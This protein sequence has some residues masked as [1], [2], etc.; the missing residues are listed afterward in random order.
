MRDRFQKDLVPSMLAII[1]MAVTI[2][3][4]RPDVVAFAQEI[5]DPDSSFKP[6]DESRLFG[7]KVPD[8][9]LRYAD[10]SR[11]RL[12]ELW[13]ERPV[14]VTLVFSRCA[15]ICSPYLGLLKKTVEQVGSGGERYQMLVISFDVRDRPTDMMA[16]A[17]YHGLQADRG[18]SFAAPASQEELT[19]LCQSL[20]FDF[21]W[22][23]ERQ[24]YNHPAITVALRAGKFVR[25]SVGE[26][27]SPGRFRE[28]LADARGEFVPIYPAPG[29]RGALFRC[30]DYDPE[31]GFT[32]NWGM[33]I[34]ILPGVAAL[35]LAAGIFIVARSAGFV[36]RKRRDVFP[37]A[38]TIYRT[39]S[40]LRALKSHHQ[41]RR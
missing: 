35:T 9:G 26:E 14:F 33:L 20:D 12:S 4:S 31:R 27:I 36:G 40:F 34:L 18:W 8:I 23:E 6:P 32:P 2:L 13:A 37:L 17:K 38:R 10:G 19:A 41:S 24:Q 29:Q 28:M 5:P 11:G 25:L 15:G 22:D 16:L 30:F 21:R 39:T 7:R 3:P 1:V